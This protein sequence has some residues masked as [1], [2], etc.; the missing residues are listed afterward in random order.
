MGIAFRGPNPSIKGHAQYKNVQNLP[1]KY[2]LPLRCS[3]QVKDHFAMYPI[4]AGNAA[5]IPPLYF[6]WNKAKN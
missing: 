1:T 6:K 4:S 2:S 5:D 3:S